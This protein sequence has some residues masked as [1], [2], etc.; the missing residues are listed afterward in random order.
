[1][2]HLDELMEPLYHV[3][4]RNFAVEPQPG[5]WNF[6]LERWPMGAARELTGRRFMSRP[7]RDEFAGMN[8]LDQRRWL[9]Q[10]VAAK[11]TARQWLWETHGTPCYPIQVSATPE[12]GG[13]FRVHSPLI[14][15][16]HDLRVTV[17]QL[18]WLSVAVLG[19]GEHRDIEARLVPDGADPAAVADELAAAMAARHPGATIGRAAGPTHVVPSRVTA[20]PPPRFAVAWT[21]A[22]TTH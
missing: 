17:S 20:G 21:E 5:G 1:V 13:R 8:L 10:L 9:L 16:G 7:E 6:L 18:E 4:D 3:P 12:G 15:E 2:F 11:D 22:G 14:P 19:D